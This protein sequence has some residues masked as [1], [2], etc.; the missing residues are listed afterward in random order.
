[1]TNPW[2]LHSGGTVTAAHQTAIKNLLNSYVQSPGTQSLRAFAGAGHAVLTYWNDQVPM[3]EAAKS[4]AGYGKRVFA[5]PDRIEEN[6]NKRFS[7]SIHYHRF[8]CYSNL[9]WRERVSSYSL[10]SHRD[11]FAELYEHYYAEGP[12]NERLQRLTR[13]PA[14]Q[15]FFDTHVHPIA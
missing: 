11:F 3:I 6:N 5:H 2:Q 10:N 8:H 7:W 1:M 15:T 14:W 4:I 12:G 9:V 13:V